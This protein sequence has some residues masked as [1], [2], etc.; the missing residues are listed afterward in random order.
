MLLNGDIP[1]IDKQNKYRVI[2]DIFKATKKM[3]AG[4]VRVG[5]WYET[6]STDRHQYD[7]DLTTGA[8]NRIEGTAAPVGHFKFPHPWPGQIPPGRTLRL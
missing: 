8:Y 4:L 3:D 5:L 6:S 7:M 2:G 1:G